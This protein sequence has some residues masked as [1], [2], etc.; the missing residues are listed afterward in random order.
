[1]SKKAYKEQREASKMALGIALHQ[2]RQEL[3]GLS[4]ED[5]AKT[6][7]GVW[8]VSDIEALVRQLT[9]EVGDLKIKES[10]K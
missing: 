8:H 6:F 10:G 5:V 2:S 9:I 7:K 1:M 4:I 3:G